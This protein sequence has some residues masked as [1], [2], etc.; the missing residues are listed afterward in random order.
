[1]AQDFLTSSGVPAGVIVMWSGS[2]A[3]IPAGWFLCNG[4][5][6]TPDLRE[7]FVVGAS[8]DQGGQSKTR[9]EMFDVTGMDYGSDAP[10]KSGGNVDHYHE[11]NMASVYFSEVDPAENNDTDIQAQKGDNGSPGVRLEVYSS[12][13]ENWSVAVP[14]FALAYIM[15]G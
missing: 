7:R 4:Q 14:Y 5:N 3:S 8:I 1:M 15:K 11:S 12:V 9:L 13:L 10:T 6:G 2:I